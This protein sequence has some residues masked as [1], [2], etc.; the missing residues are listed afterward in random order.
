VRLQ[1]E[2]FLLSEGIK[3]VYFITFGSFVSNFPVEILNKQNEG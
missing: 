3:M 1:V 2:N